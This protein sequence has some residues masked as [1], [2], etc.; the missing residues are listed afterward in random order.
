MIVNIP[1]VK[2]LLFDLG[3][4]VMDIDR[5]R[6]VRALEQ[7]GMADA[8]EFLG[9]Y[10][11][12]GPFLELERGAIGPDEFFEAIRQRIGNPG[13]SNEQITQAF[14]DFI[15]TIP[16]HRLQRLEQLG[17]MFGMYVLSNTNPVMFEGKICELFTGDGHDVHHY[18]QGLC[19]SYQARLC[20]PDPAIFH[21]AAEQFAID[22]AETLFLDDGA[23]NIEVARQCGYQTLLIPEGAEFFDQLLQ[24]TPK[25]Q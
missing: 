10:V 24:F 25:L 7:L 23:T 9:L 20:K 3:G 2:N 12:T 18:F 14:N 19:L 8:D 21:H 15:I 13:I 16:Q 5:S 4:V 6:C 1:G 11:Q 22:P 17:Q